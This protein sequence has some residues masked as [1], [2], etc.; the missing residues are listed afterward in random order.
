MNNQAKARFTRQHEKTDREKHAGLERHIHEKYGASAMLEGFMLFT[1]GE[2]EYHGMRK[3]V[4]RQ[5]ANQYNVLSFDAVMIYQGRVIS[6]ELDGSIHDKKTAKTIKRNEKYEMNHIPYIVIN[7]AELK[8][9]LGIP[10]SRPLT[11]E[12][13]NSEFDERLGKI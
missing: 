8:L 4:S 13:I 3:Y 9:K 11:Q 6:Y 7:E 5:E 10:K 12:Q 2:D 1:K